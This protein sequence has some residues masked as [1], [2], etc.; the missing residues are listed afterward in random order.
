MKMYLQFIR[1]IRARGPDVPF[2]VDA[3]RHAVSSRWDLASGSKF[4]TLYRQVHAYSMCSSFRLRSLRA[5]VTRVVEAGIPGAIVEC[6]VARGGSAALMGLT[7]RELSARRDIWL[8]DTFEGLPAPTRAD[9]DFDIAVPYTGT[10]VGTLDEVGELFARLGLQD[11]VH[12]VKGLFR[13]TI[14]C[15]DT[16]NIA[17][18]HIDGDWYD[19]VKSSLDLLYDRVSPGGLIQF[20]DFGFWAGARKAVEDF[21]RE[22]DIHT[23]LQHIDHSGRLLVKQ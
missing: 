8:F 7:L 21:M 17:V 6:G 16:G 3:F 4:S 11:D 20:D 13:H 5:A 9:P 23:A 22:R 1:N 12:F 19:S 2:I 18:L 10:C 15:A 14:P